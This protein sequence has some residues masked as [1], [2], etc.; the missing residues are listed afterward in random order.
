MK[1]FIILIAGL[2]VSTILV[3]CGGGSGGGDGGT[4]IN[5]PPGTAYQ[6]G[7]CVNGS[8]VVVNTG[9]TGFYSENYYARTLNP[10][11]PGLKNFLRDA[12]G[13]CDREHS[14]GGLADCSAW[15]QGKFDIVIRAESPQST[16]LVATFRAAPMVNPYSNY[17]YS[18]PSATQAIAGFFGLP[19]M[20]NPMPA[21]QRLNLDMVVSVTNNYQ[22]FEARGYGAAMTYANRSLVQIQVAQGKLEDQ[23]FSYRVAYRG[24]IIINGQ[25]RRCTT[26]DC[27]LSRPL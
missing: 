1:K 6:N 11:G 15:T 20:P 27:G 4:V 22:G 24:E 19:M 21:L 16:N 23:Y 8:G 26:V 18:L 5:C 10:T 9:I 17:A 2:V 3:A 25:F 14:N 12:M 7:Y 13:V